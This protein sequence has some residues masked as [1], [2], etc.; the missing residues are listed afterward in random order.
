MFRD[1]FKRQP[2]FTACLS[3]S[4]SS[5]NVTINLNSELKISERPCRSFRIVFK[6]FPFYIIV[7][8]WIHQSPPHSLFCWIFFF[9]STQRLSNDHICYFLYQI[10][11]GLKYIHSANVLHRDL[12]PSNLLLNTTCDLKVSLTGNLMRAAL[13]IFHFIRFV[14]SVSHVSPIP[15]TITPV[16]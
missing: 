15:S 2:F 4:S 6:Y 9:P 16:S 11:R 5:P 14:I 3:L 7:S 8:R 1:G 10:L 13:L 12:K